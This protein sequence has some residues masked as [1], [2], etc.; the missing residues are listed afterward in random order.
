[1]AEKQYISKVNVGGVTYEIKDQEAR[2]LIAQLAKMGV[3]FIVSTDAETTPEGVVWNKDDTEITGTLAP[4]E[5]IHEFYLV[6]SKHTSG[7][8]IYDEYVCA[9]VDGS[10]TWE[11]L[12]DTDIDIGNLGKLAYKDSA[13]VSYTPAGAVTSSFT[14][15]EGSISVSGT[16]GG[17]VTIGVQETTEAPD[18]TP[19]GT[20]TAPSFTGTKASLS[21]NFT[22]AGT[23]TAP[24]I[25]VSPTTSTVKSMATTGS[26]AS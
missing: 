3:K 7:K 6:P 20:I 2:D 1:M 14:G 22:P 26:A 10:Y 8:D 5:E 16:P 9:E 18:Y 15:N 24:T 4:S 12:G 11:K 23:I 19:S 25:T 21:A 17:T 13:S